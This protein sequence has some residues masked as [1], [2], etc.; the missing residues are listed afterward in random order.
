VDELGR[1]PP[2]VRGTEDRRCLHEVGP[3]ADDDEE[4]AHRL[5]VVASPEMGNRRTA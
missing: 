5:N 2:R 4:I 3:R 1:E